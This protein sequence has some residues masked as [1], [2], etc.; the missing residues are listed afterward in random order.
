M[1][2][3]V[4]G[5]QPVWRARSAECWAWLLCRGKKSET[6]KQYLWISAVIIESMSTKAF[7]VCKFCAIRCAANEA[8]KSKR[9]CKSKTTFDLFTLRRSKRW[10]GPFKAKTR[11]NSENYFMQTFSEHFKFGWRWSRSPL[12]HLDQTPRSQWCKKWAGFFRSNLEK[13]ETLRPSLHSLRPS[14]FYFWAQNWGPEY[15][16]ALF[17]T[18]RPSRFDFL[19]LK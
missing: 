12:K 11:H 2:S 13:W 14:F 8:W 3:L 4:F 9:S 7:L 15:A 16:H 6:I 19:K 10:S 5:E 1:Q 18:L 17:S